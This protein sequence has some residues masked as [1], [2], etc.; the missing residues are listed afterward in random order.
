[1]G[2]TPPPPPRARS[3]YVTLRDEAGVSNSP[4]Q[5]GSLARGRGDPAA[6]SAERYY[7]DYEDSDGGDDVEGRSP[8][9]PGSWWRRLL[10]GGPRERQ[11]T[12]ESGY[13][14]LIPLSDSRLRPQHTRAIIGA[15]VGVQAVDLR[16]EVPNG[17]VRAEV[18]YGGC[19]VWGGVV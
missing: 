12:P 8:G 5:S 10:G 1:M 19:A 6:L 11:E 16:V 17:D 3:H 4:P 2:S 9:G 13:L 14:T 15:L 7:S 18:S